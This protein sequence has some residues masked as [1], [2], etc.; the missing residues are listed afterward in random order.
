MDY[1]VFFRKQLD[2]LRRAGRYRVFA[3]LERH[4]GR[5]PAC[6]THH[7]G[8]RR[9][10]PRS[11]CG[12][13]TTTS[14]WVSI[15]RCSGR[16]CTKALDRLRR[17]RRRHPQHRRHQ[18]VA[19][20]VR[21]TRTGAD[22]H[23]QGSRLCCSAQRLRVEL[24]DAVDAWLVATCRAAWCCRTRTEPC[25]DDR[26]HPSQPGR[27]AASSATTTRPISSG[28]SHALDPDGA[29]AG[30]VRERLLDGRRRGTDRRVVRRRRQIRRDDLPRRGAR[31][32]VCMGRT[33]RRYRRPR[34][35]ERTG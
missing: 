30:G 32:S 29:Q 18:R 17:R 14:A 28:S 1:E 4:A 13:P 7:C 27:E 6:A 26:G 3:D 2:G 33:W 23:A 16:R 22:L 11:R 9:D 19:Q 31:A 25:V 24:G 34:G 5:F 10:G 12:A 20:A 21:G 35:A 8:R 15:R